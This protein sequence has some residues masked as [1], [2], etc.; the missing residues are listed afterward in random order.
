M[1]VSEVCWP[2][3]RAGRDLDVCFDEARDGERI[4]ERRG[5]ILWRSVWRSR[6][7]GDPGC[8]STMFELQCR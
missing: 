7:E 5:A 8:R 4:S 2:E 6:L 3:M 1:Q